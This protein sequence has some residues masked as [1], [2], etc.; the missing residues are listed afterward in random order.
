MM[1]R[2]DVDFLYLVVEEELQDSPSATPPPV[3]P[4]T[5]RTNP[6]LISTA[7]KTL[8]RVS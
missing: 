1:E 8:Q 4:N 3:P 2:D 7:L 6:S 5:K